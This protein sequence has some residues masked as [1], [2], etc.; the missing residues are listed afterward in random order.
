M[1]LLL[2]LYCSNVILF[3]FFDLTFGRPENAAVFACYF[4]E[5]EM[6]DLSGHGEG[7]LT[8]D[9]RL[10]MSVATPPAS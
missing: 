3:S 6:L 7:P 1:A 2:E 9:C 10:P 5:T 8:V 4:D